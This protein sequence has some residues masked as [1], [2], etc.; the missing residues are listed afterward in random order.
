METLPNFSMHLILPPVNL[1]PLNR[2]GRFY[3]YGLRTMIPACVCASKGSECGGLELYD[4]DL[5][6]VESN[7]QPLILAERR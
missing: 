6:A 4:C 2:Y 5:V 3:C 7:L 1:S